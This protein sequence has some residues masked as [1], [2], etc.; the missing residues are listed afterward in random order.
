MR[1]IDAISMAFRNLWR[2]KLR[3][4]LTVVAVAV[5]VTAVVSLVAVALGARNAFIGQL[6]SMGAL[7]EI[8]II[9]SKDVEQV[10]PFGGGFDMVD[11]PDA[12]KLTDELVGKI[13]NVAHVEY[14]YPEI[15]IWN[16]EVLTASVNGAEKRLRPRLSAIDVAGEQGDRLPLAAGRVFASRDETNVAV[17]G[18]SYRRRFGLEKAEDVI[19]MKVALISYPGF[20]GVNDQLP[21]E[22]ASEDEWKNHRS[23]IEVTIIGVTPPGPQDMSIFIP[24]EWAK[25]LTKRKEYQWPSEEEREEFNRKQELGLVGRNEQLGPKETLRSDFD[26]RGYPSIVAGIDDVELAET[27]A[28]QIKQDFNVGTFTAQ[29]FLEGILNIFKVIEVVL[30]IIGSIALGVAAIGI[31]NTMVMSI[32]ERTREIGVM[33]AVGASKRA[34]RRLFTLEASLIGM[35]GGALGLGVG[36]GLSLIANYIA[37][38]LL[39]EQGV[40]LTDIIEIPLYLIVGVLVFSTLIGTLAGIYPAIRAARLNPIDALHHE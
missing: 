8:R 34:I 20:F 26:E 28:E 36:Y 2:R 24:I 5:G 40:P 31:V 32:Y 21:P 22:G 25:T 14:A 39:S 38:R 12:T 35:F 27:I 1:F 17:V 37:N 3:T 4:L 23:T 9:G 16:Y 7:S 15:E 29:D 6:E 13:S 19:G 18:D 33:K 11:D 30:G 10:D